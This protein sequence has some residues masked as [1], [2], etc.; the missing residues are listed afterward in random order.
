MRREPSISPQA[1]DGEVPEEDNADGEEFG[2]VV[3]ERKAQ[4]VAKTLLP[5]AKKQMIDTGFSM[6]FADA[7]AW[8]LQVGTES[9]K[10]I[11]SAEIGRR[12]AGVMERGRN[13]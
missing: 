6:H 7:M 2:K 13:Q 11:D 8:E 1:V 5:E 4:I 3:A 9:A 12:R 10:R